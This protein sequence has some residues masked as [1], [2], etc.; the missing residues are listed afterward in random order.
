MRA[1]CFRDLRRPLRN[2]S[3]L[4]LIS[5]TS[6]RGAA[7]S[8]HAKR[9]A[10]SLGEP[11]SNLHRRVRDRRARGLPLFRRTSIKF[12]LKDK[13]RAPFRLPAPFFIRV[14]RFTV[15]DILIYYP[16]RI[17]S[18]GSRLSNALSSHRLYGV[19]R[20]TFWQRPPFST[21]LLVQ[22]FCSVTWLSAPA[23]HI[24]PSLAHFGQMCAGGCKSAVQPAILP[25][26]ARL[27]SVTWMP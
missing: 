19:R 13:G 24:F 9:A 8:Q 6:F 27:S 16:V 15:S 20:Q 2:F 10:A 21:S 7:A 25:L 18:G 4:G 26:L 12:I 17:N 3:P 14:V 11:C 5:K 1:F 23:M 22:F